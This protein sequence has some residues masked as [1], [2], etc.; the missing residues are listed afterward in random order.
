MV[1]A[2]V[3]GRHGRSAVAPYPV[4]SRCYSIEQ[5]SSKSTL[6]PCHSGQD[7]HAWRE[8]SEYTEMAGNLIESVDDIGDESG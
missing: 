4:W 6:I 5:Q 7:P 8:D 3:L 1:R 2:I